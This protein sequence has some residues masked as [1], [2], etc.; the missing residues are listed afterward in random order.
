MFHYVSQIAHG[1]YIFFAKFKER[2][3]PLVF[4]GELVPFVE[5]TQSESGCEPLA[6]I[7]EP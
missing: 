2:V 3:T 5:Q 1:H 7:S 6:A 4:L